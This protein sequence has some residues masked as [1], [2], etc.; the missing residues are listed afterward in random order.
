MEPIVQVYGGTAE[1]L[2]AY[3]INVTP[4]KGDW[5]PLGDDVF[6]FQVNVVGGRGVQPVSEPE[7]RCSLCAG[8]RC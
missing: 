2:K 6:F 4:P 8:C 7:R 3:S 5:V 1:Q